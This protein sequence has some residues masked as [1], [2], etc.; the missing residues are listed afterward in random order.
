MAKT[1]SAP[2]LETLAASI[3]TTANAAQNPFGTA[4]QVVSPGH[5]DRSRLALPRLLPAL[6]PQKW[7]DHT[8]STPRGIQWNQYSCP[9]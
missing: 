3:E 5:R 4:R 1:V 9:L 2:Q 6:P 7:S 8:L